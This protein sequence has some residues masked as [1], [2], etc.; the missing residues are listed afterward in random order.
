MIDLWL[1]EKT[2][3]SIKQSYFLVRILLKFHF[4]ESDKGKS[5]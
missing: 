5:H 2:N 4:V 1:K 3:L